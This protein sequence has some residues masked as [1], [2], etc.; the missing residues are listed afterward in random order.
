VAN[1]W[2]GISEYLATTIVELA[3]LNKIQFEVYLFKI[4]QFIPIIHFI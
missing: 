4:P 1:F 3:N 2:Q